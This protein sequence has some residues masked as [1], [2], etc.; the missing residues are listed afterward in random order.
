MIRTPVLT[1][2]LL[3]QQDALPI[4]NDWDFAIIFIVAVHNNDDFWRIW[5]IFSMFWHRDIE[6]GASFI[7][8]I[9]FID[10]HNLNFR[11]SCIDMGV[12]SMRLKWILDLWEG[13][14]IVDVWI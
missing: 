3:G 14:L 13:T 12:I 9:E 1:H 5:W 7:H 10:I 8:I 6:W 11:F 2:D 4:L